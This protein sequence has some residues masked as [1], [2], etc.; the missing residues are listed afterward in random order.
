MKTM[1]DDVEPIYRPTE[2]SSDMK[3]TNPQ[4]TDT[5]KSIE[6]DIEND[7]FNCLKVIEH[8]IDILNNYKNRCKEKIKAIK[9][10]QRKDAEELAGSDGFFNPADLIPPDLGDLD[11]E[12]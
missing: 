11:E 6:Q 4:Y 8:Q 1:F 7:P 3:V 10:K 2:L 5:F 9:A 12:D